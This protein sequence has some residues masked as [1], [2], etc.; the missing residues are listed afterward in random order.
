MNSNQIQ[1]KNWSLISKIIFRFSFS[2]FTVF[3]LL[4]FLALFIET[5]LRWFADTILN[6]G[7]DFK[8]ESTGSGDRSFD[9]VRFFLNLIL[10]FF[11]CI[12]WSIL[13]KKRTSYTTLFYWFQSV[14][15]L[16]LC[17]AMILYGLAK[18]FKGQFADPSL[19]FLLQPVGELSPMGLAWVFMGH[20]M[21]Y[22]IF[23]GSLEI[24]GGLLLLYRKTS[25]LGSLL[26]LGIMM[27]VTIMNLTYDIPVKLFSIH[28]VLMA[29][30]LLVANGKRVLNFFLK[31]EA[32]EKLLY[33]NY[34]KNKSFLKV[35]R[36]FKKATI[37]IVTILVILQCF[38]NFKATEQLRSNSE[39][40]GIWKVE[41]FTKQNDTLAPLLT[42]SF[43]W[44]YLIIDYKKKAVVKKMNDTIERYS[45]EENT[46]TKELILKSSTDSISQKFTYSISNSNQL[47]LKGDHLN[48]SFKKVPTSQFRLLNRKFHW[49]NE[50]TYMY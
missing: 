2:Y 17:I 25:T 46:E 24:L 20:S 7:A 30:I 45:F 12:V 43:R 21:V 14:L 8:M 29:F 41:T 34:I 49:I 23:L 5:P 47:K 40:R 31:N 37:I 44:R 36:F 33:I 18:V 35:I 11:T 16:F 26:I 10:A 28:L 13:D 38:I 6:W 27:N 50:T 39:I 19:E 32:T 48:I 9:Y 42:D 22:N 15:R 4:L 3:I 1:S